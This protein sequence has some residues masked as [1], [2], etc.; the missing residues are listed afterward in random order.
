[1]HSVPHVAP[2]RKLLAAAVLTLAATLPGAPAQASNCTTNLQGIVSSAGA[3][4]GQP[5]ACAPQVGRPE[6]TGTGR[7]IG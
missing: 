6:G 5:E 1:V 3:A 4:Q 7:K 2:L